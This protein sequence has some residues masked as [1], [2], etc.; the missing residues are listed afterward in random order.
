MGGLCRTPISL[1]VHVGTGINAM[2]SAAVSIRCKK[3]ESGRLKCQCSRT[4]VL[5][6]REPSLVGFLL[7]L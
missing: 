2:H 5:V 3:G 4:G 7:T 1:F 6:I